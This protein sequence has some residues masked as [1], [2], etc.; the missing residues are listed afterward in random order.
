ME[1]LVNQLDSCIFCLQCRVGIAATC[2]YGLRHEFKA[3]NPKMKM[4]R[5][6]DVLGAL[7]RTKADD[8]LT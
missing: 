7:L 6:T 8:W 2:T 5:P 3:Y 4:P 1:R